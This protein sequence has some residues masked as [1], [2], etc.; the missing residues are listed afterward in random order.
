MK[1]KVTLGQS[2]F[3]N[4]FLPVQKIHTRSCADICHHAILHVG[5]LVSFRYVVFWTQEAVACRM[6]ILDYSRMVSLD[7]LAALEIRFI[8][9]GSL[10]GSSHRPTLSPDNKYPNPLGAVIRRVT[11]TL[12]IIVYR[13]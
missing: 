8:S 9:L 6:G 2:S 5:D 1:N 4:C 3:P 10:R 13:F 11:R 7:S 12:E